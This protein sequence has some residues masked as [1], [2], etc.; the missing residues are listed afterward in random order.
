MRQLLLAAA[1]TLVLRAQAPPDTAALLKQLE[2][3]TGLAAKR[4]IRSEAI[5]REQ[6]KKF[7]EDRVREEVKP[8]EIRVEELV[9]KKFGLVPA[10]FDLKK[11][12]ID[13]MTEQAAAFYDFHRKRLFMLRASPGAIEE[14]VLFHELAHAVTDQHFRLERFLRGAGK[15]DD[16]TLARMAVMEGQ[17]TWLM[18]ELLAQ[19]MGR[20]LKD[21]PELV[22]MMS[23]AVGGSGGQ[24]P[25]FESSP[26]YLRESLVFP[27]AQGMAF[28]QAV[29]LKLGQP[30]FAEVF[31]R[32]PASTQQVLHPEKYFAR[33]APRPVKLP[34][35]A[36]RQYKVSAE[37]NLGEF[38]HSILLRQFASD[39]QAAA[40]APRWTGDG[41]R[42][43][44]HK[45]DRSAV[46]AYASC[47]ESE[48]AAREFFAAWKQV[49]AGKWKGFQ[50]VEETVLAVTGSGGGGKF[51]A[52][53]EGLCMSSIEGLH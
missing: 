46:L 25:V 41:Y 48:A 30:A 15:S 19:R 51:E 39:Q 23:K 33:A 52:R 34:R 53:L 18:S 13:L 26:L 4:P 10:D 9:L 50:I 7:L 3:I 16:G 17:A 5:T 2:Q 31:R 36:G 29:V 42:L 6:L 20:S 47:W 1:L 21:S 14:P 32:P 49:L 40:L 22:E 35:P 11:S 43:Y 45:R 38:D 37:G 8:E 27:Y 44:E 12:T 28:Q 24:F